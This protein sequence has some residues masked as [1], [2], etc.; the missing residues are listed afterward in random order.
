[1]TS[2]Y[3]PPMDQLLH[4]VAYPGFPRG[5]GANS[6]GGRQPMILSIFAENCMKMK[7]FWPPGGGGARPLRPPPL[8][9]PLPFKIE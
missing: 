2:Y 1:M 5:G 4:S 8:D 9:P 6:Q 7:T 3:P